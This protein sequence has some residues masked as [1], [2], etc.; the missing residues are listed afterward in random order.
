MFDAGGIR[1]GYMLRSAS[2]LVTALSLAWLATPEEEK[3]KTW[4]RFGSMSCILGRSESLDLRL[5]R[6]VGSIDE[7]MMW[8]VDRGG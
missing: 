3:G 6:A 1:I 2:M 4:R 7:V 8:G 5:G